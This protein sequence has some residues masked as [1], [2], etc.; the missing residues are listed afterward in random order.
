M[1]NTTWLHTH[2]WVGAIV[3]G[4]DVVLSTIAMVLLW[5]NDR[6]AR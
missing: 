4:A 6:R 3:L 2:S 1:R 5:L